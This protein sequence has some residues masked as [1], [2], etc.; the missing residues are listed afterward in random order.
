MKNLKIKTIEKLE[1][2]KNN[3]SYD[4]E[5]DYCDMVNTMIDYDNEAQ[6]N[7]YLYD[8]LRDCVEFV[9]WE[10]ME[11]LISQCENDV[12]RLRCFI[13]DTYS[14][15]IYKLDGYGNLENVDKSDFEYCIEEAIDILETSLKE[16]K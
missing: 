7:L 6:D 1:E 11:Y 10:D 14:A 13:G 9:T 2:L 15:D 8:H 12:D 3:L 4:W 16:E 5:Q